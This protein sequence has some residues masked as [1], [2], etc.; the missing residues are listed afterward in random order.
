[1]AK[2]Y[3]NPIGFID[4]TTDNRTIFLLNNPKDSLELKLDTPVTVWRYSPEQLALTKIRGAHKRRRIR[5]GHLQNSRIRHRSPV[6]GGRGGPP[7]EN[8]CLSGPG[9][10]F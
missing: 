10:H 4:R 7:R 8:P 6:A 2:P 1:M 5:D 3:I 9:R